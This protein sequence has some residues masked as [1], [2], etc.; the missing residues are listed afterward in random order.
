M[1]TDYLLLL[2]VSYW[3][4]TSPTYVILIHYLSG[5]CHL[6]IYSVSCVI[7]CLSWVIS[8]RLMSLLRHLAWLSR[9]YLA[10]SAFFR[11]FSRL[12]G[13][14]AYFLFS[15]F[16]YMLDTY[17][18]LLFSRSSQPSGDRGSQKW[19]LCEVFRV[20]LAVFVVYSVLFPNLIIVLP[21]FSY[22]I[23]F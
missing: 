18:L 13:A 22:F 10:F 12:F 21:F 8:V 9:L 16:Q 11:I 1:S 3:I 4:I 2:T 6:T 14:L 19:A 5:F 7:F 15:F 20:V 17:R 23:R